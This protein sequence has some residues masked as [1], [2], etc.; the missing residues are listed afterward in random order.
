[1]VQIV[2][3]ILV[4]VSLPLQSDV[5]VGNLGA[6]KPHQ[7]RPKVPEPNDVHAEDEGLVCLDDV[8]LFVIDDNI[9]VSARHQEDEGPQRYTPH[10][11][12]AREKSRD[13]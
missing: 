9:V 8:Y 3:I 2:H 10:R 1:M 12:E 11:I 6:T 4:V 13:V 7:T 5:L